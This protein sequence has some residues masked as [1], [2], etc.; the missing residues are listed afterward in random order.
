M[1]KIETY[2][3]YP[4]T[5]QETKVQNETYLKSVAQDESTV[6]TNI[7]ILFPTCLEV[8]KD[9]DIIQIYNNTKILAF[10]KINLGLACKVKTLLPWPAQMAK[11]STDKVYCAK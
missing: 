3:W 2:P 4:K 7:H 6:N 9:Q 11:H 8:K 1:V 10:T 5:V